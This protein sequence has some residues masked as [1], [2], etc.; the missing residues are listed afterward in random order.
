MSP[1]RMCHF[2]LGLFELKAMEAPKDTGRA[3]YLPL[4]CLKEFR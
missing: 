1:P 2:G 4:N 3:F